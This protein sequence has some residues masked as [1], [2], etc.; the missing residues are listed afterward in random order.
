MPEDQENGIAEAP[1]FLLWLAFGGRLVLELAWILEY[2][3][4]NLFNNQL[5]YRHLWAKHESCRAKVNHFKCEGTI[6]TG[7]DRRRSEMYK[8]STPC[9]AALALNSGS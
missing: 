7:M 3:S 2:L 5:G 6:P 1:P 8:Q 9:P 4:G